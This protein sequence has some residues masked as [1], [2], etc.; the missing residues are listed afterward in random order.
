[1]VLLLNTMHKKLETAYLYVSFPQ[2]SL[3]LIFRSSAFRPLPLPLPR[4][5]P[6]PLRPPL[7]GL[8]A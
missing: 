4:P 7:P 3:K 5:R 1:M 8:L 6:L 2:K